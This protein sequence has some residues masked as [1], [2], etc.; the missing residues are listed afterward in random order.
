MNKPTNATLIPTVIEQDGRVERAYDIYSRLLKD[1]I[2]FLGDGVNEHT[3]NLIVAQLLFL[4]NEDTNKDIFLYINS[5]GGSV[6]DALAIYD[7]M[8]YVKSDIQTVGIGVQASAAA[9]LLSS[10]TKGKRFL[11]PHSTVMIHQPS[12]GTRG[13]VT[14]QEI[15]L[16]ESLRVKKLL[17]EIMAKNT[18]Q[19]VSRIHDDMERDKWLTAEEAKDYGIVDK[20][21]KTPP[22]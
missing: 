4:D 6:Y 11:L 1:R 17:E 7:T 12:S 3:A 10:G 15:D 18:G 9:F 8:K 2:I 19:K 13:K 20:V 14:D 5:P 21:I 16:R 22:K